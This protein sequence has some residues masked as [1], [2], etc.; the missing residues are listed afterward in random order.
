MTFFFIAVDQQIFNRENYLVLDGILPFYNAAS[1]K[2]H[3]NPNLPT[4]C[5]KL[6]FLIASSNPKLLAAVV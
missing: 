3:I 2:I 6:I 4:P 5:T 1:A